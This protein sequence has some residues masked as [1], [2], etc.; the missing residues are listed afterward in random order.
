MERPCCQIIILTICC[1]L[2]GVFSRA[3]GQQPSFH[4]RSSQTEPILENSK[5]RQLLSLDTEKLFSLGYGQTDKDSALLYYS[6]AISKEENIRGD[7]TSMNYV[8]RSLIN[9]AYIY[10][11]YLGNISESYRLLRH[12][13]EI[14]GQYE[15][16]SVLSHVYLNLSEIFTTSEHVE[17]VNSAMPGERES[18]KYLREAFRIARESGNSQVMAF[19]IYNMSNSWLGINDE[20]LAAY[21]RLYTESVK[22]TGAPYYKFTDLLCRGHIALHEGKFDEAQGY[23]H[24]MEGQ[25]EVVALID[26]RMNH[27]SK[28][29]SGIILEQKGSPQE[30]LQKFR[31]IYDDAVKMSDMKSILWI[32]SILASFFERQGDSA[33]ADKYHLHYYRTR[34]ALQMAGFGESIHELDLYTVIGEFDKEI[35]E[36]KIR[37]RRNKLIILAISAGGGFLIIMLSLF[38]WYSRKRRQFIMKLYEKNQEIAAAPCPPGHDAEEKTKAMSLR[39]DSHLSEKDSLL[40]KE[41]SEILSDCGV[42][43][44]PGFQMSSLC[45]AVGSNP[46]YVSRAINSHYGKNFKTL[47]TELRIKEACRRLDNPSESDRYTIETISNEVGFKS[48]AAFSTAFK[49]V[50]GLSPS[51]YRNAAKRYAPRNGS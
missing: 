25:E 5:R 4:S 34:E 28:Y 14:C 12:A 41:I 11:N 48:R 20:E 23:F 21:S 47:L 18:W 3:W 27:Y 17:G 50:T 1:L 19:S 6:A 10:N 31:E 24:G 29:L 42:I 39:P 40:I 44:N 22:D 8:A 16:S 37:D 26:R 49:N 13:E 36:S 33:N 46:S 38:L 7:S 2:A 9:A 43:C 51:E 35:A 45:D 32:S 15:M 30:A